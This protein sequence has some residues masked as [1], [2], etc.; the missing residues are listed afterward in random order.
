LESCLFF[1][2]EPNTIYWYK[3]PEGHRHPAL[4]VFTEEWLHRHGLLE[5]FNR[6]QELL[7]VNTYQIS[8]AEICGK[9]EKAYQYGVSFQPGG[10][11]QR[12]QLTKIARKE[13]KING[14]EINYRLL[15][16]CNKVAS[17][18]LPELASAERRHENLKHASLIPGPKGSDI[19]TNQQQNFASIGAN[20]ADEI[21]KFGDP[22]PDPDDDIT[23]LTFMLNMSNLPLAE[24]K[25][26]VINKYH[27]GRSVVPALKAAITMRPRSVVGFSATFLHLL[28]QF[29]D[30]QSQRVRQCVS[31]LASLI[32]LPLSSTRRVVLST[33][34]SD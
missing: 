4:F 32:Y 1:E 5:E 3:L 11:P 15:D 16:F 6:L 30:T 18:G 14:S 24:H 17:I 33:V 26:Q 8:L 20:L 25:G 2:P 23:S 7:L 9:R 10:G 22:H 27:G 21:G 31:L 34:S 29:W 12:A 28:S 13:D 19:F